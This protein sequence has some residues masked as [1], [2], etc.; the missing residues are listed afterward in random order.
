MKPEKVL[1]QP[2]PSIMDFRE[3]DT[4]ITKSESIRKDLSFG[5]GIDAIFPFDLKV[6]DI[7]RPTCSTEYCDAN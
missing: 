1:K 4:L 7:Q 3:S 5:K 2:I 6:P